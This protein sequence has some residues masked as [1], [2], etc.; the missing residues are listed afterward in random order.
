MT[1]VTPMLERSVVSSISMAFAS[2]DF[3]SCKLLSSAGFHVEA[4]RDAMRH[5]GFQTYA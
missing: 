3:E 4:D 2:W 1:D 5:L